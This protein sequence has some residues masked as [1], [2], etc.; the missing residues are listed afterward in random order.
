MTNKNYFQRP[1]LERY[2]A[3]TDEQGLGAVDAVNDDRPPRSQWGEAWASLRKRPLFWVSAVLILCTIALALHAFV[4]Y[5]IPWVNQL[6]VTHLALTVKA[7]IFM[8]APFMAH[9]LRWP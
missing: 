1:R 8:P 2:V 7:A 4:N 5:Q 6:P 3:D 9:A